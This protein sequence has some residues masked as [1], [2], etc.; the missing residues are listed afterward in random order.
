MIFKKVGLEVLQSFIVNGELL[1]ESCGFLTL[2]KIYCG[3]K[4]LSTNRIVLM[5]RN[6]MQAAINA[7]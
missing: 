5:C 7:S 3:Y 4:L 2:R 1:R 6:S